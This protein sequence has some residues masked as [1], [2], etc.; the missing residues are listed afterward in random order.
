MHLVFYIDDSSFRCETMVAALKTMGVRCRSFAD[1]PAACSAMS[2]ATPDATVIDAIDPSLDGLRAV[3][4]I[5]DSGY[6]N[7]L[8]VVA[9]RFTSDSRAA[10]AA[11]GA[12]PVLKSGDFEGVFAGLN[13]AVSV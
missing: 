13:L 10:L 9:D 7:A 2:T 6:E 5:R 1:V 8:V 4:R 3:R 11:L 12:T